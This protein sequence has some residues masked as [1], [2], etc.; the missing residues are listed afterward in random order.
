LQEVNARDEYGQTA[1]HRAAMNGSLACVSLLIAK[2]CQVNTGDV[3]GKTQRS[4]TTPRYTQ[5][6]ALF[7]IREY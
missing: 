6:E 7:D 2:G 3:T 1:L 4:A 5:Y